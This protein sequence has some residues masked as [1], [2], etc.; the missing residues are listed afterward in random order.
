MRFLHVDVNL[1]IKCHFVLLSVRKNADISHAGIE[2][3]GKRAH[4]REIH[5]RKIR[6]D[7]NDGGPA[8]SLSTYPV[9]VGPRRGPPHTI[10]SG[11]I[12]IYL[13]IQRARH[14]AGVGVFVAV[15]RDA[16]GVSAD[17][18]RAPRVR[19]RLDTRG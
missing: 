19:A 10:P 17:A 3:L 7:F 9:P 5:H 14:A 11:N 15:A 6:L 8:A 1:D 4:R 18:P 12:Q 13:V 16:R 2:V